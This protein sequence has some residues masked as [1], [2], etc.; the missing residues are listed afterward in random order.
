MEK[1][2]ARYHRQESS[3]V[4]PANSLHVHRD[5]ISVWNQI[6]EEGELTLDESSLVPLDADDETVPEEFGDAIRRSKAISEIARTFNEEQGVHVTHAVFGWLKWTDETG[7]L[8]PND[9]SVTLMD[10]RNVRVVRS[11][12]IFVPVNVQRQSR[13]WTVSLELNSAIESNITLEYAVKD[14]FGI[15]I[16]I[17]EDEI[18]PNFVLEY[19]QKAIQGKD[20]WEV[21]TGDDVVIDTFSFKKIALLREIERS[22]SRIANHPLLRLPQGPHNPPD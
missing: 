8:R 3:I 17:G 16:E 6:V 18:E 10:G 14:R 11:P 7:E 12:L 9:E 2:I 19:W 4:L 20:R 1:P 13:G 21:Y 22:T 5:P 15:N